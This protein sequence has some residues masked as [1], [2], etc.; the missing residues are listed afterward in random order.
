[1]SLLENL[2]VA[3]ENIDRCLTIISERNFGIYDYGEDSNLPCKIILNGLNKDVFRVE[4]NNQIEINFIAIDH[5]ILDNTGP[6]K[7]DCVLFTDSDF[8]FIEIKM[9]SSIKQRS[10]R[11]K[12]A[13]KQLESTISIFKGSGIFHNVTLNKE[14]IVCILG[15]ETYPTRLSVNFERAKYFMDKYSVDLKIATIKKY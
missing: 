12:D 2:Q 5:C 3:Y 9:P 7:C 15:R 13:Y 1:M 14:A 11:K 4:N 6:K 10:K 8:S